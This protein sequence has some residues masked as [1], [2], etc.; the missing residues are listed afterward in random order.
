MVEMGEHLGRGSCRSLFIILEHIVF[1]GY[2]LSNLTGEFFAY[3]KD[4]FNKWENDI[5]VAG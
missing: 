1:C 5:I 3:S 4:V 2:F